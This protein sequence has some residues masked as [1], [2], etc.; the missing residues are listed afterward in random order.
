MLMI[1]QRNTLEYVEATAESNLTAPLATAQSTNKTPLA[2]AESTVTVVSR[3]DSHKSLPAGQPDYSQSN[4]VEYGCIRT[5]RS[6]CLCA[7]FRNRDYL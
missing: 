4:Q 5:F 7:L 6:F 1:V 3:I 2:A